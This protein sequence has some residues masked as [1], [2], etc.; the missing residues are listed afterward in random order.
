MNSFTKPL[1]VTLIQTVVIFLSMVLALFIS[2]I[3]NGANLSQSLNIFVLLFI[4][5]WAAIV[6]IP[7]LL[8]GSII[9]SSLKPLEEHRFSM[10]AA[11]I[12]AGLGFLNILI[13]S[14]FRGSEEFGGLNF[15]TFKILALPFLISLVFWVILSKKYLQIKN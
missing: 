7:F 9:L 3:L 10:A 2:I 15:Q 8:F 1:L 11:L 4:A 5:L 13:N 14:F 12:G 6:S